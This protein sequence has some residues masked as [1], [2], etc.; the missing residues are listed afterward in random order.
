M[1]KIKLPDTWYGI[2][3]AGN[4]LYVSGG[5]QNCV[6]TFDLKKGKL[7]TADTIYFAKPRPQYNGSLE[8]LDVQN[9][10]LA[11]VFRNDS[12][13]RVMNMKS[14]GQEVVKLDGMP[15]TCVFLKDGSVM[16]SIWGSKKVEVFK[17][18][19][20]QYEIPTGDHPNEITLSSKCDFAYVACSNDNTVTIIDVAQEE[21]NSV[22]LYCNSS[23]CTGRFYNE[24]Y[25]SW[26]QIRKEYLQRT[27]T[28]IRLQSS[29]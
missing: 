15:Y 12:T 23:R 14:K 3:F 28:I 22:C 9:S 13:F 16:V 27:Q 11:V 17:K 5:Y 18:M 2:K 21:S 29:I 24:F 4:K 20:L 1:Q 7:I 25:C 19:K 8:G 6:F 10:L 26:Y